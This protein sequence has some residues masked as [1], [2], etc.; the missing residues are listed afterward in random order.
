MGKLPI[1]INTIV[2]CLVDLPNFDLQKDKAY[3][4][5]SYTKGNYEY[6]MVIDDHGRERGWINIEN[7]ITLEEARSEKLKEIGI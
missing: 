5:I 2:I 7:F 4:A 6:Y 1:N 3:K